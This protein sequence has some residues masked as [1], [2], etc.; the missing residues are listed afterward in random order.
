MLT[1]RTVVFASAV[2]VIGV[3]AVLVVA[4]WNYDV[5]ETKRVMLTTVH[6][7]PAGAVE[8]IERAGEIGWLR[9]CQKNGVRQGPFVYWKKQRK[10]AEGSYIDGRHAGPVSYFDENGRVARVDENPQ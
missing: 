3:A 2:V 9:L 6:K 7:C 8:S 10:Y 5:E 4:F 1:R